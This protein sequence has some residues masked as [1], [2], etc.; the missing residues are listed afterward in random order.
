MKKI[1]SIAFEKTTQKSCLR[2]LSSKLAK[3]RCRKG[4]IGGEGHPGKKAKNREILELHRTG[5]I[6]DST[7]DNIKRLF[8]CTLHRYCLS[9]SAIIIETRHATNIPGW[10][11]FLVE[12]SF[13]VQ[14]L[15]SIHANN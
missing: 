9:R 5:A 15:G 10:I 7:V 3:N 6:E 1:L 11:R 2:R 12:S 8:L 14:R 4:R 13:S